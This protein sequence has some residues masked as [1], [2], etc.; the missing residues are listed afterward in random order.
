MGPHIHVSIYIY[1]RYVVRRYFT[2]ANLA[3]ELQCLAPDLVVSP[4]VSKDCHFLKAER[5]GRVTGV[6]P[7]LSKI[8]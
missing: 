3:E 4:G 8:N 2:L 5:G 6:L 1:S 7:R